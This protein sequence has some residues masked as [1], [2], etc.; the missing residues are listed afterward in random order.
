VLL[1]ALR[2]RLA[3][4]GRPQTPAAPM[5]RVNLDGR[6][7]LSEL[8]LTRSL[9]ENAY[10]DELAK[11]QGRL[12]ELVRDPRFKNRSLVCAFEGADA[13]GKGGAIRRIT[14]ALDARQYQVTPVAAPTEEEKAQ[15]HLWRFWRQ[16]PRHGQVAILTAPGMAECWWSGWRAFAPKTTGCVPTLK[17]T[18]LS[19]R[20]SKPG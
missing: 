5:V 2:N 6:N 20:S 19:M 13:A 3:N 7:V 15:P 14:A 11:W 17:L 8:D 9:P 4:P 12:S 18:T 1:D 16:L 10:K